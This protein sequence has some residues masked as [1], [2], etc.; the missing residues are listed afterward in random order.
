MDSTRRRALSS[1]AGS[2]GR[3]S[4]FMTK[5]NRPWSDESC[6]THYRGCQARRARSR[7]AMRKRTL[8][9]RFQ[10]CI[11]TIGPLPYCNVTVRAA[12]RCPPGPRRG[13]RKASYEAGEMSPLRGKVTTQHVPRPSLEL[14]VTPPPSCLAKTS[15][16]L[17]PKPF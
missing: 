2:R 4:R 11:R 16:I 7:P 5:G 9:A 3:T 15:I 6:R 8:S 13:H 14:V 10:G 1:E 12:A 17:M